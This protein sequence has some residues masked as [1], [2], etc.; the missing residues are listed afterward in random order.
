M[1]IVGQ[2]VV[3]YGQ[4]QGRGHRYPA[5]ELESFQAIARSE[6]FGGLVALVVA[7]QDKGE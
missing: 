3:D 2:R 6:R 1:A 4:T 7:G 5:K